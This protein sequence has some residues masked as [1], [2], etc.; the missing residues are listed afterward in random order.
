M[1]VTQS[2]TFNSTIPYYGEFSHGKSSWKWS[3]NPSSYLMKLKTWDGTWLIYLLQ[4]LMRHLLNA[5]LRLVESAAW[6]LPSQASFAFADTCL[7]NNQIIIS[8]RTSYS[9]ETNHSDRIKW[10][11]GN[12]Y[13][14]NR[15]LV[16]RGFNSKQRFEK[17]KNSRQK[18][19]PATRNL[20]VLI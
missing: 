2:S 12:G 18:D 20:I 3:K 8:F 10:L 7:W 1:L 13:I 14:I 5:G 16:A 17:N 15:N 4:V 6:L 9:K 11:L 19:Q